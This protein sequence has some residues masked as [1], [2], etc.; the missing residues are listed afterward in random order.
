MG[1]IPVRSHLPLPKSVKDLLRRLLL[2]MM[3]HLSFA[4][5][6]P[7]PKPRTAWRRPPWPVGTR[8][9]RR[10]GAHSSRRPDRTSA[11]AP[12]LDRRPRQAPF[13]CGTFTAPK[14]P[15]SAAC[16]R[17]RSR[18]P[19]PGS[20]LAKQSRHS[21]SMAAD[22]LASKASEWVWGGWDGLDQA[23]QGASKWV[24]ELT[25]AVFDSKGISDTGGSITLALPLS[26]LAVWQ[27][28]AT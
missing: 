21:A 14:T 11:E 16:R 5:L 7:R 26:N 13:G 3:V 17:R 23:A 8:P 15:C 10:S 25:A 9:G 12:S 1:Y 20:S 27:A 18:R 19:L 28:P 24:L 22:L 2:L 4:A 6:R